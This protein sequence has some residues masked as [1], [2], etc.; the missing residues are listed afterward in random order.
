YNYYIH[1]AP[2][3][4]KG[5]VCDTS[6]FPNFRWHIEIMPRLGQFGGFELGTGLEINPVAPEA[7]AQFLREQQPPKPVS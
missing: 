6:I 2:C 4:D 7:A 3:D 1:S 5:F